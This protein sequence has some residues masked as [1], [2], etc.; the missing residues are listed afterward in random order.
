MISEISIYDSKDDESMVIQFDKNLGKI[1][2]ILIPCKAMFDFLPVD[3]SSK[4]PEVL[5]T[6]KFAETKIEQ[7]FENETYAK[8]IEEGRAI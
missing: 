2:S 4:L 7:Y 1:V 6:I 3:L 8:D 5:R